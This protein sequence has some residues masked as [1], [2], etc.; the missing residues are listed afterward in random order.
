MDVKKLKEIQ[1]VSNTEQASH[2]LG[3]R[4]GTP[5]KRKKSDKVRVI[6]RGTSHEWLLKVTYRLNG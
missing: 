6:L 2:R 1:M 4:K 3:E 5:L